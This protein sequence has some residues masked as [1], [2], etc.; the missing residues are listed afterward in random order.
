ME[1]EWEILERRNNVENNGRGGVA[2]YVIKSVIERCWLEES[3]KRETSAA[4]RLLKSW[5]PV[6]TRASPSF[7]LGIRTESYVSHRVLQSLHWR[8]A[9]THGGHVDE[10]KKLSTALSKGATRSSAP[11]NETFLR[12]CLSL[13][14]LL[15]PILPSAARK[16]SSTVSFPRSFDRACAVSAIS[17]SLVCPIICNSFPSFS[18]LGLYLIFHSNPT[19]YS[20]FEWNR[21]IK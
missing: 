12:S 7:S 10:G 17:Y 14:S 15:F 20:S 16:R 4:N 8:A 2:C 11:E 9:G 13:R 18:S 1:R 6:F 19:K 3:R 5:D 21:T